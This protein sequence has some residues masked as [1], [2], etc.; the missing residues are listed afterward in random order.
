[1][2]SYIITCKDDAT[3]EQVQAAKQHAKDQGGKITHEYSL[4]K[5]FA[6]EF[7]SDAVNTLESHEHVKTV[8]EDGKMTTQ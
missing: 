6:C 3:D 5:G 4:I 8:E 1:M 7:P 2:P